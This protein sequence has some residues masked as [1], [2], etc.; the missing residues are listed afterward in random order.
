M[1]PRVEPHCPSLTTEVDLDCL[2]RLRGRMTCHFSGSS[3]R[4]EVS[5]L[6]RQ[7]ETGHPTLHYFSEPIISPQELATNT[8]SELEVSD[9][10]TGRIS[11]PKD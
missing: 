2:Y 5:Q 1:Q 11:I 3:E 6:Q 4:I 10:T 7:Y 8:L 9:C